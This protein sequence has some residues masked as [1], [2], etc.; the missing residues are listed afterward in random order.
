M[1]TVL[2]VIFLARYLSSQAF[3]TES[4]ASF[5][6]P[7]AIMIAFQ[8]IMLMQPDFGAAMSLAFLT[9]TMLFLSGTRLRYI[10]SL[11]L[12]ALPILFILIREPY[13]LRRI[14]SFLDPWKDPLGSG[15]QLVQSFIAFGSG[16]ITGVGIG[17][18]KQKLSYL[19][20]SHT[21]FIFSIIGEEFG[22]IGV[23]IIIALFVLIFFRGFS[24]ANRTQD[25]FTYYLAVGLSLM[26][27]V[28]ALVNFAV[29]TGL[30]P[31]KGLPLPFISY[32]G[33]SLLMNMAAIG[34]LLNISRGKDY[35]EPD[36]MRIKMAAR[37][38]AISAKYKIKNDK[39]EMCG[40]P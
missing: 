24:I 26:I 4:F 3:R 11:A 38:K 12:F 40:I 5:I 32:G 29:A 20:E 27:S 14:I 17:G 35:P 28:Q 7:V 10:L 16:G 6:K 9:I 13:R 36:N 37:R 18:S 39:E 23:S 1:D 8:A 30:V 2:A 21:D 34:I 25:K 19:P 22:F 33:S 31:T 15:F